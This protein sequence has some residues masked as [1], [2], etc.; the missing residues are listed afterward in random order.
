MHEKDEYRIFNHDLKI[1]TA[2]IKNMLAKADLEN[3]GFNKEVTTRIITRKDLTTQIITEYFLYKS[4]DCNNVVTVQLQLASLLPGVWGGDI[5][6]K[7]RQMVKKK[8]ISSIQKCTVGIEIHF[9][10]TGCQS[11]P[12]NQG[13]QPYQL[14]RRALNK[15][16]SR[17]AENTCGFWCV[18][19]ITYITEE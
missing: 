13:D 16:N 12:V 10:Q 14:S 9:P 18:I 8:F 17:S 6:N 2:Q 7:T 4:V 15:L 19:C 11:R 5:T 3:R 1:T